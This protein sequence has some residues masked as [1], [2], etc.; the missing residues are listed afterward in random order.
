MHPCF[1][2]HGIFTD[3]CVSQV[4]MKVLESAFLE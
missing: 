4:V 2:S 1:L 3:S